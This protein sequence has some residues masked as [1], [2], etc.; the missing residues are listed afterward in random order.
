MRKLI[1]F[2]IA[3]IGSLLQFEP[4]IAA[5]NCAIGVAAIGVS[6]IGACQISPKPT[7]RAHPRHRATE[8][9]R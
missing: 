2:S 4:S 9:R 3:I 1:A 6:P 5:N 8:K 7:R